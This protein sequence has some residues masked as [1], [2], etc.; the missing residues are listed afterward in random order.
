M[1][2]I[3]I[4]R[5][6]KRRVSRKGKAP[7]KA[8]K[9]DTV[10]GQRK[11]KQVYKSLSTRIRKLE[12]SSRPEKKHFVPATTIDQVSV[13]QCNVNA[14]AFYSQD[15]TPYMSQNGTSSGRIGDKVLLTG[16]V[17]KGCMLGQAS[18]AARMKCKFIIAHVVGVPYGSASSALADMYDRNPLT[19]MYD[20]N[21]SRSTDTYS[22]FRVIATRD[23]SVPVDQYSGAPGFYNFTI[24]L[25][26]RHSLEYRDDG[27]AN[28]KS[29]Q[30]VLF[31][32][33]DSGNTNPTTASS[34]PNV[35]IITA[36]SGMKLSM[37]LDY[38]Y[39]DV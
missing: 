19:S 28:I 7:K 34:L 21:V 9:F 33:C 36:N 13:G 4:M 6:Y 20:Y 35:P 31:V 16:L 17:I 5:N 3:I 15:L 8:V 32:L 22:N 12:I 14:D 24:P 11:V 29:G 39:T 1:F 30:L 25:K 2:S 23:Y 37:K 27:T 18:Q 38:Y 26:L 10:K